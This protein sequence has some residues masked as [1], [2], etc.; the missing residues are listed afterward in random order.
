MFI[1][2]P[3]VLLATKVV[4]WRNNKTIVIGDELIS[5]K[6]RATNKKTTRNPLL[7]LAINLFPNDITFYHPYFHLFFFT[8]FVFTTFGLLY[9]NRKPNLSVQVR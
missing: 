7:P 8:F 4:K 2:L 6:N 5:S 1:I 3:V 9:Q